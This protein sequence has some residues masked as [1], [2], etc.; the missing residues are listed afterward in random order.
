MNLTDLTPH[1]A[2]YSR[3]RKFLVGVSGGCDSMVLLHLLHRAGFQKLVVCHLNH[4]LRGKAAQ[5]D[6]KLVERTAAQ[7]GYPCRLD[8]V[9]VRDLA[10]QQQQSIE[11]AARVARHAFFLR[12]AKAERTKDIFLAHH[13]DDQAE[14]ILMNVLRGSSLRGLTG[15]KSMTTLANSLRLLRPFLEVRRETLRELAVNERIRFR[16]DASND[17]SEYVRNRI[18][19]ELL[20]LGADILQR[21]VVESL[22]RLAETVREDEAALVQMTSAF[23]CGETLRTKDLL[24]QPV[25]IQR[26]VLNDWL[27]SHQVPEISFR[28]IERIRSLMQPAGPAKLNLP[29]DRFVR[30][31]RGELFIES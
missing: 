1:L 18:R 9:N 21:D 19:L 11:T 15:M 29:G 22:L 31:R 27:Q 28:W 2:D 26:R 14:T 5:A 13:A 20:P 7:L 6:A 4:A 16:D 12:C 8:T 3:R 24:A 30:R 17:S 10:K 25:A 23:I